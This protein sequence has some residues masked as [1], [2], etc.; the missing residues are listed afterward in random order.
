MRLELANFPVERITLG[1]ETGYADGELRIDAEDIR[2]RMLNEAYFEDVAVHV[3]HPGDSIRI[4]HIVDVVEPRHKAFGSGCIFPGVLGPPAQVGN[5]RTARMSGMTVMTTSTPA[6]GEGYYW[7]E[8]M[9]DMSGP[10]A[11]YSPFSANASLVLEIT[12]KVPGPEVPA[13]DL[14]IDLTRSEGRHIARG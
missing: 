11:R 9:V 5:G 1:D 3:A 10:G 8:A 4:I 7:R 13:E 12:P 6:V 2:S 14:E